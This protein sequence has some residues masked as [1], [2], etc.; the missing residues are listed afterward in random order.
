MLEDKE[1]ATTVSGTLTHAG[2]LT[3]MPPSPNPKT[4]ACAKDPYALMGSFKR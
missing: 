1:H 4:I 3:A 2:P